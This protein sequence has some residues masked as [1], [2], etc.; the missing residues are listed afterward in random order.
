[1]YNN[2]YPNYYN[3][4]PQI[5]QNGQYYQGYQN[6]KTQVIKVHGIDGA[7]TYNLAPSSSV[8]LL[9]ETASRIFLKSTDDAGYPSIVSYR[10]DL[11][12]EEPTKEYSDLENRIKKLEE[13][14]N[15]K[16]NTSKSKQKSESE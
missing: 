13:M 6:T 15:E 5:N 1:M 12:E 4:N 9:D 8:L 2:F 14:F 3:Q 7:K 10:I 11:W 16:P